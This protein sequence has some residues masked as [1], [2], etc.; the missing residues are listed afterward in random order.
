[1]CQ[2]TWV[3]GA[4]LAGI[5]ENL[6]SLQ[7]TASLPLRHMQEQYWG[8]C[9]ESSSPGQRQRLTQTTARPRRQTFTSVII[10]NE[11]LFYRTCLRKGC[12]IK[13]NKAKF[14][15]KSSVIFRSK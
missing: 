6:V 2:L 13:I 1:M 5:W 9:T 7:T 11:N 12:H 4:M 10:K 14:T 15:F 8:H 3:L